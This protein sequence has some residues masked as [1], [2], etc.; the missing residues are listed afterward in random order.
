VAEA[1]WP[2]PNITPQILSLNPGGT[3]GAK[4]GP[5]IRIERLSPQS[6]GEACGAWCGFGI[7]PEKPTDQ[8]IDDGRSIYFESEP[9]TERLEIMG[10]PK[11]A[12]QLTVDRPVAFVAVRLNEVTP[13]GSSTR[14]TYGLLNLTHRASHEHPEPVTPGERLGVTVQ[15]N[16]IAHGF[17]AGNRIRVAISTS[18]WPLV[19]PS[20]EPV[21]LGVFTGSST[22]ELPVR[23]PRDEDRKL[24]R[25][26]DSEGAPPLGKTYHRPAAGR[27]WVER[28]IGSGTTTYH[29]EEDH[30]RFTIDHIGLET[31]FSERESYRIRDDDPLSAEIDI[32]Y[33]I[34][35]GRGEWQT[36]TETRCVMRADK[37]HF[38]LDATLDAFEGETRLLSRNWQERIPRDFM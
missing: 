19:W 1:A 9:L 2:S 29:I 17:A 38:I 26:G 24:P 13:D 6:V 28:D 32:A 10:A 7:G 5:E 20:P 14:I 31:D 34:A 25:F 15:L 22:L 18:Y 35:I 27:R 36:R 12:L 3:L 8:R 30:G 4:P 33:S 11:L 37:T 16:D 23:A 21:T